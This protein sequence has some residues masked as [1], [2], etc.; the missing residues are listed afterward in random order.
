VLV[1]F[2]FRGEAR[3]VRLRG[4]L[5]SVGD[6]E[7]SRED[8]DWT[9]TLDLPSDLRVV[10]WFGLDGEDDWTRWLP[11]QANAN[12]YIYPAGLEFTGDDEVVG[13]LLELPDAR[14]WRWSAERD[15]PHGE[16]VERE[17]DGRRVWLYAPAGEPEA[18]L[19]GQRTAALVGG[20][21]DVRECGEVRPPVPDSMRMRHCACAIIDNSDRSP[22]AARPGG[23]PAAAPNEA[24]FARRTKP[25]RRGK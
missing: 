5:E 25:S 16:V 18:L 2:R 1:T 11:D 24:K 10:Y 8:G 17:I 21:V 15:V 12:R 3:S 4:S 13:S 22:V 6:T 14:P 7:L 23:A 19:L 9:L 20:L